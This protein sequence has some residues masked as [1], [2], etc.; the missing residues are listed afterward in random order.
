[1]PGIDTI[2]QATGFGAFLWMA[3]Y[4][5]TRADRQRPQTLLT[6][7]ALFSMALFFFSSGFISNTHGT[8]LPWLVRGFWW[9]NVFPVAFWFHISQQI[10]R[11]EEPPLFTPAVWVSYGVAVLITLLGCFTSLILVYPPESPEG[12]ASNYLGPGSLFWGY[13]VYMLVALLWAIWN[14]GLA[15]SREARNPAQSY[16]SQTELPAPVSLARKLWVLLLGGGLFLLGALYLAVRQQISP[17]SRIEEWPGVLVLLIGLGLLA[18]SVSHYDMMVAGKNIGRDFAY[19]ITG[20]IV[21]N[22]LYVGLVGLAGGLSSYILFV[23]V[24]LAT[25]THTLYD[26]GLEQL[27]RLFFSRAEQEARSE[28]RAYATAL[29]SAPVT[30]SVENAFSLEPEV[31]TEGE[32]LDPVDEKSFNNVVRRAIT[33]LKNP[34]QLVKNQLLTLRLVERRLKEAGLDDNRLNRS[35]VLREVLLEAI[36]RLRPTGL[37]GPATE[38]GTGD[39]WRFY[40][41]LYFPYVRQISRKTALTEARRLEVERKRSG[42]G[43]ASE[44]EQVLNWLTDV[45]EATFYKWQRRASDTIASLLREEEI[46]LAVPPTSRQ[47]ALSRPE[48]AL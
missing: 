48:T 35:I 37:S 38:P 42:P 27:D 10:I 30:A 46:R 15:L 22:L 14:I 26:F 12:P 17:T 13:I 1:M 19:S 25:T 7:A 6:F 39:A 24:G 3:L 47:P 28:A 36:E 16:Y 41:V 9:S 18:Y 34:T 32:G 40:N 2:V 33:H 43:G 29:A 23:L 21:I 4:I 20:V 44:L 5:L 11:R 8:A 45:D 31:E